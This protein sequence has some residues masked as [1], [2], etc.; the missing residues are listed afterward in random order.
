VAEGADTDAGADAAASAPPTLLALRNIG[1]AYAGVQALQGVDFA[2]RSGEVH[3]LLGENGAGKSTL[4]KIMF[5]V[6]RPNV[7][8]IVLDGVG[9]VNI[10]G[11]RHALALGIGL[12]SQELSLAPQLDVAQN[13]FLGQSQALRFVRRDARRARA[14]ALLRPLAPDIAV[15]AKVGS[16][17]M[18]ARQVVEIA[19]TLALGGCMIAFDEPTSSLTPAERDALFRIIAD[20][21]ASGRGIIYI[22]H[23]MTE[24]HAIADRVTVL[25]DGRV[26]ASG[27]LARFGASELDTLIAGRVLSAEAKRPATKPPTGAPALLELR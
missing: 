11:P 1:K 16:L 26:V 7:G 12:V 15:T 13:I 2:L 9:P 27:P 24:V 23:R 10:A 5:G 17:G 8:E 4:M 18:A 25:R 19:R 3:T 22:S 21:K 6:V 20:L 14:A